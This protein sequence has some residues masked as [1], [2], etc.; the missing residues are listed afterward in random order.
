MGPRERSPSTDQL[1]IF[2]VKQFTKELQRGAKRGLGH[3]GC[4][5]QMARLS[6]RGDTVTLLTDHNPLAWLRKQKDPRYRYA[7]WIMEL[8]ALNCQIVYRKGRD[9]QFVD[10]LSRLPAGNLVTTRN[11]RRRDLFRRYGVLNSGG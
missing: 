9:N 7:R 4:H 3:H 10:F 11:Q 8:E 2:S 6:E 5:A 1:L